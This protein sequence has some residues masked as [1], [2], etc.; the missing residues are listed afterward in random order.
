MRTLCWAVLTISAT[1]TG[2][3]GWVAWHYQSVWMLIVTLHGCWVTYRALR[4]VIEA[5][6][7]IIKWAEATSESV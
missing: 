7:F 5:H 3:S 4:A 6:K 1:A 2:A